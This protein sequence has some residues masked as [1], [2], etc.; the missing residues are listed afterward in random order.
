[1]TL[2]IHCYSK[3]HEALQE[4]SLRVLSDIL[5]IHHTLL[6]PVPSLNDSN[7]V[8]PPPFQK[9]LLKT[10]AKALKTSA[11]PDVQTAAAT[12]LAKLLLSGT[13]S[14]S[15]PMVPPSIKELNENSV[16]TL[17]QAMVLS[18]FHPRTRENLALRQALTYFLPVY[19]HSRL[20]NAQHMRK[21][22]V[23]VVRAVLAAADEFY[24]LEAAEDSDGDIDESVGEKEI[25]ALMS[26]VVGM[27]TEW[28][29]DRRIVGLGG[30]AQLP[31]L[32][33]IPP[34]PAFRPAESL[35]LAVARDILHRILGLGSVSAA[36][37]EEKKYLLSMMSKLHM[38]SPPPAPSRGGSRPPEGVD[39][40]ESLR[41]ST[42]SGRNEQQPQAEVSE[43]GME[44][45][46]E[47]KELLDQAIS[48]G[49]A[50]DATGRN[51]LVKVKNS[52][53]KLVALAKDSSHS[54]AGIA[55]S[56]KGRSGREREME[57]S[58]KEEDEEIGDVTNTTMTTTTTKMTNN[59]GNSTREPSVAVTASER[60]DYDGD[61]D[62]D[63]GEDTVI[64][65]REGSH[66]ESTVDS[67][68]EDVSAAE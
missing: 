34:P 14:P 42:R 68:M 22:A 12:A 4:M 47:I 53:L 20:A 19:C 38:P 33:S 1:M 62:G 26:N 25:K 65:T 50:S 3:G 46:N 40:R 30:E 58:I 52:V 44:L 17:L 60:G 39:E 63:G 55:G 6:L 54:I 7:S 51:A 23:P 27:L 5:T 49:V 32:S 61:G 57:A 43:E 41:S 56:S 66:R 11:H 31:G 10:F 28:T 15:G 2:F 64:A 29:D 45:L 9:P 37:K 16:D 36:P 59:E 48:S 67:V 35:H 13:L 8:V 21:I 24:S 18:F